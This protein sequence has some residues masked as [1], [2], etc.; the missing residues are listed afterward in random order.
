MQEPQILAFTAQHVAKLTGLSLRQL[1]YWNKL[2]FFRPEYVDY[3]S[4]TF[5][6]VY[7]FRDVVGLRTLGI[8]RKTYN[9][10]LQELRK[11]DDYLSAHYSQ[12]W[13]TLSFYIAGR[14]VVFSDPSTGLLMSGKS[15]GQIAI[16]FFMEKVASDAAKEAELLKRRSED[17]IGEV[18]RNR[19]VVHNAVVV[20]G[21]RIPTAS[22]WNLHQAGYSVEEI[23][24][25]Y[26]SLQP[27]DV[28]AS[29]AYEER[30]HRQ[31][32]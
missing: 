22:V 19:Y 1:G 9:I 5:G 18:S 21:T 3:G 2:G 12:P 8:L 28:E 10:P 15:G 23:I 31:A 14:S 6:R 17:E 11:V 20:A 32:V 25:E 27:R 7:S 29:L 30:T 13:S 26:P 16:Q 24:S 4:R